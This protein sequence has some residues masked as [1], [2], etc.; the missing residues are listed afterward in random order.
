MRQSPGTFLSESNAGVMDRAAE[1]R[2]RLGG[3]EGMLIDAQ[4]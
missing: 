3:K 4:G 1:E 2:V